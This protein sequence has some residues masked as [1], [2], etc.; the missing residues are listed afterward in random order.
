MTLPPGCSIMKEPPRAQHRR[1][2]R[3]VLSC[4]A[5]GP[6]SL[7]NGGFIH[8]FTNKPMVHGPILFSIVRLPAH[9]VEGR[10]AQMLVSFQPFWALMLLLRFRAHMDDPSATYEYRSSPQGLAALR[11]CVPA[12]TGTH[13]VH[14]I[15]RRAKKSFSAQ[16]STSQMHILGLGLFG[17]GLHWWNLLISNSICNATNLHPNLP[18]MSTMSQIPISVSMRITP[19]PNPGRLTSDDFEHFTT[20]HSE[21]PRMSTSNKCFGKRVCNEGLGFSWLR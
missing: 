4:L 7:F 5:C 10:S 20:G 16:D 2:K 8:R 14:T 18:T 15:A 1:A 19:N 11:L 9:T 12:F 13:P 21:L 17:V 3:T 6:A